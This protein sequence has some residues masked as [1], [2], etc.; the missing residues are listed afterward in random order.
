MSDQS[1]LTYGNDENVC[2]NG[3]YTKDGSATNIYFFCFDRQ[4]TNK[5]LALQ[6]VLENGLFDPIQPT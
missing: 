5:R 1:I 3:F 4:F 2:K 6:N